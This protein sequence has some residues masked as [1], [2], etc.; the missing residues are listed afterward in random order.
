MTEII[1][2]K[3]EKNY[4]E[5][6]VEDLDMK[7]SLLHLAAKQNF[8]HVSRCLVERYPSLLYQEATD[9]HKSWP[10]ELALRN[11]NDDI[12]AY[13]ISKMQYDR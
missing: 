11:R 2:D 12:A 5:F 7:P 3:D 1:L 4:E 6:F 8:L 10:V 9:D 13:L